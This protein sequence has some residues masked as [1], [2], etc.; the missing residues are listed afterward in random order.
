MGKEEKHFRFGEDNNTSACL[1]EGFMVAVE[2]SDSQGQVEK[3][4][5][6]QQGWMTRSPHVPVESPEC[7]YPSSDLETQTVGQNQ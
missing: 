3:R 5:R 6:G 7:H 2:L 1:L 4:M